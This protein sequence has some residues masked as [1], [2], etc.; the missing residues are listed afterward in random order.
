[1]VSNGC[2]MLHSF[3]VFLLLSFTYQ[4]CAEASDVQSPGKIFQNLGL[5][6]DIWPV[7]ESV[8]RPSLQGES[9]RKEAQPSEHVLR[10]ASKL[11]DELGSTS[12]PGDGEEIAVIE[13]DT[14]DNQVD[15]ADRD[16]SVVA[17]PPD[18]DSLISAMQG[19]QTSL[20]VHQRKRMI[21]FFADTL[22]SP[23]GEEDDDALD[24]VTVLDHLGLL[25]T[26]GI[27]A[28]NSTQT[29]VKPKF[30][31][32]GQHKPWPGRKTSLPKGK[33]FSTVCKCVKGTKP[34][35]DMVRKG[36]EIF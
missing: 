34:T 18:R 3:V 17:M 31:C 1:M 23:P 22:S 4:K 36:Q 27:S 30:S 12:Q 33:P 13:E 7:V 19:L 32:S 29:A 5:P 11:A 10:Q 28:A 14:S 16:E 15:D 6:D 2:D 8:I 25:H 24:M 35:S 20:S 21:E 9:L 26:S